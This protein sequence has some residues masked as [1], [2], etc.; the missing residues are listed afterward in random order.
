MLAAAPGPALMIVVEP[1]EIELFTERRGVERRRVLAEREVVRIG[2]SE[3][4]PASSSRRKA[5]MARVTTSLLS[6]RP[7]EVMHELERGVR[8][9][10]PRSARLEAPRIA[11]RSART[12]PLSCRTCRAGTREVDG[13][14]VRVPVLVVDAVAEVERTL[15][16]GL[17]EDDRP[18]GKRSDDSS[19][20]QALSQR[21]ESARN[22]RLA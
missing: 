22:A 11:R 1:E 2:S 6:F 12:A 19:L 4:P 17:H 10:A 20:A 15:V 7:V 3:S 13:E 16:V 5:R 8:C 21:A 18:S 14:R 9:Q